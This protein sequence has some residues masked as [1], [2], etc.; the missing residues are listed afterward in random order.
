[1]AM[2]R[3]SSRTFLILAANFATGTTLAEGDFNFDGKVDL[4]DFAG[5]KQAFNAQGAATAAAVPEPGSLALLGLGI[6]AAVAFARRR[7]HL[8]KPLVPVAAFCVLGVAVNAA[9]AVDFNGRLIRIDL[10]DQ[11]IRSTVPPKHAGSPTAPSPTWSLP[12]T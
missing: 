11:T 6:G 8:V 7:R 5:L 12:K 3:W 2:A 9:M 10:L 4:A 1:M